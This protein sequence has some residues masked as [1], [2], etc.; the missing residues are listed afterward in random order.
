[1]VFPKGGTVRHLCTLVSLFAALLLTATAGASP[2]DELR[3]RLA[4]A[5]P[6]AT[7]IV[8]AGFYDGPFVIE[9][10]IHLIGLPG[11]ILRG[12]RRTHVVDVT[13][14][15]VEITGF[16][17]RGSGL[18]LS[19]DHAGVHVTADRAMIHNNRI[20]D[21]LHGVYVRK[22]TACRI[23]HNVIRG[24][25]TAEPDE[26]DDPLARPIRP[27]QGEL[28]GAGLSQDNRGNGIHLWNSSG[29]VIADN[30]IADTRDGIYF[31]FTDRVDVHDNSIARVRYGLHYMYSDNNT[32]E[33][34]TFTASAAGAALMYSKGLRLSANHF[35]GNRGQR[36]YGL[37]FQS[38]DDTEVI[39]NLIEGNTLGLY[40]ENSNNV[41]IR[42]NRIAHNYIGLRI[43]DSTRDCVLT[44]NS[45]AGNL[46]PV[47]TNGTNTANTWSVDGTGNHWDGALSIDL[48]H[49]GIGDVPHREVDLFGRWRR[50]FPAI[51]L[52]SASPG[53][54]LLRLIRGRLTPPGEGKSIGDDHPLMH[55]PVSP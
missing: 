21:N 20:I 37:L 44:G 26:I 24:A 18:D 42:A 36:A 17:I 41:A 40:L 12:D 6:G 50:T 53:E 27:G 31:S 48:D 30:D 43:N 52:L 15:D 35:V 1:M 46:H 33:R 19:A 2:G 54:R 11:A 22:A 5:A 55:S 47:E 8:D 7:L 45:F 51:G 14:P 32:F 23:E 49:D 39:S 3:A 25:T 38:V 9:K 28:C 4:A 16:V 34:N 29:H 13:A 10:T